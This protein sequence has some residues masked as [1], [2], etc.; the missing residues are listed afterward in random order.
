MQAHTTG[1]LTKEEELQSIDA[2]VIPGTLVLEAAAPY[3]GYFGSNLPDDELPESFYIILHD[4]VHSR[5]IFRIMQDLANYTDYEFEASPCDLT[6]YTHIY[7]AIRIRGIKDYKVLSFIQNGLLDLGY[8]LAKFKKI[9]TVAKIRIEK[10]FNL[11]LW[12]N[13]GYKDL[14]DNFMSYIHIPKYVTWTQF[15]ATTL[16][17]KNNINSI[18]YDIAYAELLLGKMVDTVRIYSDKI[19]FEELQDIQSKY[20]HY[21]K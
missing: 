13:I 7:R 4:W 10:Y 20:A 17:V 15:K 8:K 18:N 6:I 12:E 21:L 11:Q 1:Y 3:P 14:D 19:S 16:R 2:H 5:K 9:K